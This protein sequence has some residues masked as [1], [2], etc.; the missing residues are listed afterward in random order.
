MTGI[1]QSVCKAADLIQGMLDSTDFNFSLHN[2]QCDQLNVVLEE[3]RPQF[4]SE[5]GKAIGK[6]IANISAF[7]KIVKFT[8]KLAECKLMDN[9]TVQ[10]P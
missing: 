1:Q 7:E 8:C 5:R 6:H 4:S 9:F 10:L 3:L 2:E